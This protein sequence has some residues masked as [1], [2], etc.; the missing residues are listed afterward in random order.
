MLSTKQ[1]IFQFNLNE[2]IKALIVSKLN[3]IN[4]SV[5]DEEFD[6]IFIHQYSGWNITDIHG[7]NFHSIK[8]EYVG[9]D[10]SVKDAI[11]ELERE[12]VK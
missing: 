7:T 4:E 10:Q 1:F 8:I 12:Y 6:D 9:N 5:G 2:A 3:S 11:E